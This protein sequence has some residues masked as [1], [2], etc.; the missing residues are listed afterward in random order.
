MGHEACI[1]SVPID[2]KVQQSMVC[3]HNSSAYELCAAPNRDSLHL[4]NTSEK[5]VLIVNISGL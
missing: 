4:I 3:V 1:R 5:G 2:N